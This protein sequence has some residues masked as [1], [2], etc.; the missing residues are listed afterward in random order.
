[1]AEQQGRWVTVNGAHVFIKDGE[2]PS[3][4]N[5]LQKT[6]Q[7]DKKRKEGESYGKWKVRITRDFIEDVIEKINKFNNSKDRQDPTNN[8]LGITNTDLQAMVEAFVKENGF[9]FLDEQRILD[10]I[11]DRTKI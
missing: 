11:R 1:M 5:K 7:D 3:Y 8:D 10:E 6:V 9:D 2:Q 4:N